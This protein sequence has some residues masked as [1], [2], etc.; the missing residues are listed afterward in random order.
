[1]GWNPVNHVHLEIVES[2]ARKL[3]LNAS[4]SNPS[5]PKNLG[6]SA[7]KL[8][9]SASSWSTGSSGFASKPFPHTVEARKLEHY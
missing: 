8:A 1:M 2:S 7:W 4:T 6:S 9:L 3:P 5:S